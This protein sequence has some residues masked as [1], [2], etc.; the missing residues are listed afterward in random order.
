MKSRL[1]LLL[2]LALPLLPGCARSYVITLTNGSRLVSAGKPRLE[3]ST[4]TYKDV[5]G[6]KFT[7]SALRV[8]EIAPTSMSSSE[9]STGEH[10]EFLK[11]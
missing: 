5:R 6:E 9:F 4:Y 10:S 3:G 11:K 2:L 7:V 1:P 8:R